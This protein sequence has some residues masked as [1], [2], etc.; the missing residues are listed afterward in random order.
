LQLFFSFSPFSGKQFKSQHSCQLPRLFLSDQ[1]RSRLLLLLPACSSVAA[2]AVAR[3]D[4]SGSDFKFTAADSWQLRKWSAT[5]RQSSSTA[6]SLSRSS[7]SSTTSCTSTACRGWRLTTW[8]TFWENVR[9]LGINEIFIYFKAW[10]F[11]T[12]QIFNV[13]LI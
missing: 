7:H 12:F 9:E 8:R 13:Y 6:D 3:A 10:N 2:G 4:G 5:K 11:L 1:R